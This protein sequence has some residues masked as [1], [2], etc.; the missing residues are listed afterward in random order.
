MCEK[1]PA[2]SIAIDYRLFYQRSYVKVQYCAT[3]ILLVFLQKL[4]HRV[5]GNTGTMNGNGYNDCP[6]RFEFPQFLCHST[7]E[8]TFAHSNSS[9]WH[10]SDTQ[11]I[12]E[13]TYITTHSTNNANQWVWHTF[14]G[15]QM[16]LKQIPF[17]WYVELSVLVLSS[18][19]K[20]TPG[21]SWCPLKEGFSGKDVA[22][23]Q[24]ETSLHPHCYKLSPI[25]SLVVKTNHKW[26]STHIG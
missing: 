15:Q 23:K 3:T 14:Q 16:R 13:N 22:W 17:H 2:T 12:Q 7:D 20:Y 21:I 1:E 8:E 18:D 9:G 11:T 6:F 24:C 19:A 4:H 25:D 10:N 26:H 5:V